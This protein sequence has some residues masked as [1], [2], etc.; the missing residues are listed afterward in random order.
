MPLPTYQPQGVGRLAQVD[1]NAPPSSFGAGNG[2]DVAANSLSNAGATFEEI[3]MKND[4]LWAQDQAL[5]SSIKWQEN[6]EQVKQAAN[7][8]PQN[9]GDVVGQFKKN[10]NKYQADTLATAPN[11]NAKN[12]LAQHLNRLGANLVGTA[13]DIQSKALVDSATQNYT[14]SLDSLKQLSNNTVITE[15]KDGT[16]SS[17]NEDIRHQSLSAAGHVSGILP[18]GA[19]RGSQIEMQK[20]LDEQD[21]SAATQQLGAG[22]TALYLSKGALGKNLDLL[23]RQQMVLSLIRQEQENHNQAVHVTRQNV[24]S[25]TLL[26][27]QGKDD[28]ILTNIHMEDFKKA[29]GSNQLGFALDAERDITDARDKGAAQQQITDMVTRADNTYKTPQGKK[30]FLALMADPTHQPS[31]QEQQDF[32]SLVSVPRVEDQGDPR[33][34]LARIQ[35]AQDEFKQQIDASRQLATMKQQTYGSPITTSNFTAQQLDTDSPGSPVSKGYANFAANREKMAKDDP[36]LLSAVEEPTVSNAFKQEAAIRSG[37]SGSQLDDIVT[38]AIDPTGQAGNLVSEQMASQKH[39][40]GVRASLSYQNRIG[41]K[42][43]AVMPASEASV[44]ASALTNAGSSQELIGLVKKMQTNFAEYF[45]KAI[46]Q[47]HNDPN[48]PLPYG[49][50]LVIANAESNDPNTLD[51][52]NAISIPMGEGTDKK[53]GFKKMFKD[54]TTNEKAIDLAISENETLSKYSDA[55][56]L[57]NPDSAQM[58]FEMKEAV[59]KYARSIYLSSTGTKDPTAAVDKAV[60]RAVG[61]HIDFGQSNGGTYVINREGPQGRYSDEDTALVKGQLDKELESISSGY[62]GQRNVPDYTDKYNTPLS[63]EEEKSFQSWK[64]KYAANDSG[65][66]YDLRGAFKDGIKPD[67]ERGHFPDTYKKPN[68]P[69][70]SDQSKYSSKDLPG[71]TW[72]EGDSFTPSSTNLN[73]YGKQGLQDYFKKVEPNSKLLIPDAGDPLTIYRTAKWITNSDM[74]G[75]SLVVDA[76]EDGVSIPVP[77]SFRSFENMRVKALQKKSGRTWQEF[78]APK[79]PLAM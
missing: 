47:L 27:A 44:W 25:D 40:E 29:L 12:V 7:A 68:H 31:L 63:T 42:N 38:S 14:S 45:P 10:F 56:A 49:I 74:S 11:G 54:D 6:F 24:I 76:T 28:P 32:V 18:Q 2:L 77:N 4:E 72:G 1:V 15:G 50:G 20:F 33:P 52:A 55:A 58:L 64:S 75:V 66:D 71:G 78:L 19:V 57:A 35:Q 67:D 5:K 65:A 3:G 41:I 34:R 37:M 48:N 51:I 17:S 36:F 70:F 53:P 9:A 62:E 39:I 73:T 22:K 43:P 79:L 69:T 16:V 23:Q 46:A 13:L 59:G 61:K 8:D 21:I 26:A 60:Q 30:D